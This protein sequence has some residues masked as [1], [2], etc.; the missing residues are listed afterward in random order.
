MLIPI[1]TRI[2]RAPGALPDSVAAASRYAA[3]SSAGFVTRLP[4]ATALRIGRQS[5]QSVPY[6]RWI[7][8]S[9]PS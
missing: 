5:A 8:L 9:M 6:C 7:H 1:P 4:S 3:P 2:I